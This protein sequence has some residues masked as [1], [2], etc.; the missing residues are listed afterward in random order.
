MRNL[1]T[2][3]G[4]IIA[5]VTAL[6]APIGYGIIGYLK[7]AQSLKYRAELTAS[8]AAQYIYAPD[9]PWKYDTDQ[10]AAI[11]EI[12]TPTAVPI[13]QRLIDKQGAA[14]MQKGKALPWPTFARD[15]P[16]F[17][18]GAMVGTAQVSASLRPLLTEVGFVALGALVLAI[19]AYFAFAILPLGV[20]DRTLGELGAANDK[21]E[22]QNLLLDTAL[23]NMAQ[24]LAMYDAEARIVIAN[25]RY[26]RLYG[27][28]PEQTKSGTSLRKIVELRMA[29]GLYAGQ[30]VDDVYKTMRERLYTNV[31]SHVTNKLPDG[32]VIV[33]T[34]QPRADGGWVVTHQD[35]SE[36]E[37]LNAQL[38][39]QNGLLKQRE[40]ELKAQNERFNAAINNMSQGMS[41]FDSEQRVV[42]ANRRFAEIY[43]LAPEEVRPG[44]TLR[45]ILT[46]RAA[47]EASTTTSMPPSSSMRVSP[48]SARRCRTSCTWRTAASSP[49]CAGPWPMAAWSARTRTS[50]SA[51]SSTRAWPRRTT[52]RAGRRRSSR[53]KTSASTRP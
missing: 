8:R 39:R 3:L 38:A 37:T 50:P 40:E 31:V 9:A 12:V 42:F 49:S 16:I 24:G 10:L 51:R 44:T 4:G 11:S 32:R 17:A 35:V 36:R 52:S 19:A 15:A 5:I 7:E 21:L 43:G 20:I 47:Q 34:I 1:V 23:E 30:N 28:D 6:S 25:D 41:L 26:A 27:L 33:A 29:S 22:K 2:L 46:A 53:R 48:A 18:S 45:Q 14:M 13:V